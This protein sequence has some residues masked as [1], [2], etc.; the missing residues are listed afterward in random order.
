MISRR[1]WIALTAGAGAALAVNPRFLFA[2]G[3]IITRAIPSTGEKLPVVGLGTANT[4]SATAQGE[5]ADSLRAVIKALLDAGGTVVDTAP[6][7]GASEGVSGRLAGDLGATNKIFWATKV[8]VAG[9]GGGSANRDDAIAQI[10]RSFQLLKKPKIDLIQVHN[11]GDVP[12]QLAILKEFKQQGRVRY[13]GVTTTSD[14]QYTQLEQ[15]MRNEPIDFIEVDYSLA[16]RNVEEVILPLAIERKIGVMPALP[17]GR[18]SLFRR[19]AGKPLPD[20]AKDFDATTWSHYFLKYIIGHPAITVAIPGT[21]NPAHMTDN[22]GAA[23][24]RLPDEATRKRM[25]EYFDSVAL[26]A[27]A[28]R[29]GRGG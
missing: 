2:Q 9:R 13:I 22:M 6:G 27:A 23:F 5:E 21:R 3:S 12:T 24:G 7:Y 25:I 19:V 28:G 15:I 14:N 16:N 8:N 11:L 29:G 18:E 1:E 4:F 17:F 20:W 26:P 10:E